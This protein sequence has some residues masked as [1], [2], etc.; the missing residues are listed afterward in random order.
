[1]TDIHLQNQ[2]FYRA[3]LLLRSLLQNGLSH[4]VIS[5]GSRSTPLTMAAAVLPQ[6]KKHVI[7][8]ERSAAFMALGIG[9]TTNTPAALICTSGTAVANY[10]PAVIEARKSGIPML[11]L[12]ADRPAHLQKTGANQ[13]VNQKKIFGTFPVLFKHID[14]TT[15]AEKSI[16]DQLAK[17]VF[18][19]AK[20]QKGPVHLNVPFAKPLEPQPDF[21]RAIAQ[22]NKDLG[23]N[24]A[25]TT[26]PNTKQTFQLDDEITTEIEAARKPLVIVGQTA[27][28]T[29]IEAVSQWAASL[30]APILSE[31]GNLDCKLTIAGFEGFLR[32]PGT[33]SKLEPD[34]ILRFG[35]QPASKSLLNAIQKWQP[36]AHIHFSDTG[37]ISDIAQTTTHFIKWSNRSLPENLSSKASDQ[38]HQRWEKTETAYRDELQSCLTKTKNLTDGHIYHH[39]SPNIPDDWSVFISNS[40]PARDQSM[41]ARW[42]TQALFTN[43][44]VSGIDGITS[45]AAGI[46]IGS[47]KPVI[48][49][50]GDLAFLHDTNALL[51]KK[52]LQQPLVII[53]IN[54]KG[55]S[56]FR[57]LPIAEHQEYFETY[58]ETPQKVNIKRLAAAYNLNYELIDTPM[59][60]QK[61]SLQQYK[62]PG[63]SIVE[64]KTDPDASMRVREE[65]W[66]F[67]L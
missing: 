1:M 15:G 6:L 35:R 48:L 38:W 39:I 56:I 3:T 22:E 33:Q 28:G 36:K 12:T 52:E 66:D 30:N 29:N 27:P 50:T 21:L 53:V 8:D 63:I 17:Q 25:Q 60:L 51:N 7:L 13:T 67:S 59:K 61:L 44:G 57:M 16:Y 26:R 46:N 9:K 37:E 32:A 47:N 20:K 31:Q 19:C 23:F 4:V 49:F 34:I 2:G 54:N 14:E 10:Y 24:S 65:V 45:T 55:G 5:P 64:C 18:S 58:F 11:L 40:F 62:S 42:G 43:R 41:F